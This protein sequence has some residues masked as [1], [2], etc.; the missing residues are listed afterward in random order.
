V[1]AEAASVL[2]LGL[3]Q[4]GVVLGA[5]SN[6]EFD[7]A[8]HAEKGWHLFVAAVGSTRSTPAASL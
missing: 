2:F 3:I 7:V 5:V 8:A 1:D 6:G 4:P